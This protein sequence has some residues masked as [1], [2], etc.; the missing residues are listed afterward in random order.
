MFKVFR[1]KD[2]GYILQTDNHSVYVGSLTK[3]IVIMSDIG[4]DF[5]EIEY[6][7]SELEVNQDDVA[8]YGIN[9]QFIFSRK[10]A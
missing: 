8:H 4:V 3:L 1:I 7:L 5:D 10:V 2:G 6:G 9:K